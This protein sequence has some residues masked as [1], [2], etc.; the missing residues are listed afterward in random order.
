[1]ASKVREEGKAAGDGTESADNNAYKD[2]TNNG[3]NIS[4][5]TAYNGEDDANKVTDEATKL[6][7]SMR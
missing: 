5:E 4:E 6:S 3:N 2:L 7:L 1:M